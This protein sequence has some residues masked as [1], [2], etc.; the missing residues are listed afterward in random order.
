[1]PSQALS[2]LFFGDIVGKPGRKAVIAALPELK[3]KYQPDLV[4]ANVENLAH[5]IGVTKKTLDEIKSAGVEFFTSGNHIWGKPEVYD[6]F[7]DADYPLIRPDNYGTSVPG[8]GAREVRVGEHTLL[9]INL[10]GQVFI[11][12]ELE[13]PFTALDHILTDH[14]GPYAGIIVDFHAEAT[15]EKVAFGW[16]SDGR[17][18]AVLGTHT[19]VPTADERILPQGTAYLSDVGMCGLRNSVIG[20][21]TDVILDKFRGVDSRAHEITDH[22]EAVVNAVILTI[23]P[24]T[25]HTITID[26]IQQFLTV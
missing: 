20:I 19:H 23:D 13:N 2:I 8:T 3:K 17:V 26:R 25:G 24:T 7:K 10:H 18:S 9:V 12:E 15:S 14:R 21:D 16:H 22:G 11:P 5:G 1:M 6:I 4:I